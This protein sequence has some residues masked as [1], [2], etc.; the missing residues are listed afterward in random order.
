MSE[1]N[2]AAVDDSEAAVAA[3]RGPSYTSAED[4]CLV[5]AFMRTSED[6]IVGANQRSNQFK[7]KFF[8]EYKRLIKDVNGR[9]GT[10]FPDRTQA[11]AFNRFKKMSRLALKLI[12][13]KASVGDPPSGDTEREEWDKAVKKAF[14]TRNANAKN[15]IENVYTCKNFLE[16]FP[17]WR[18]YEEDDQAAANKKR[19]R[20]EGNKKAKE[21]KADQ[22]FVLNCLSSTS[23]ANNEEA[24]KKQRLMEKKEEALSVIGESMSMV[25]KAMVN[26]QELQLLPYLSP[27]SKKKLANAMFNKKMA[28]LEAEHQGNGNAD[29]GRN[30]S[31]RVSDMTATRDNVSSPLTTN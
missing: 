6:S 31:N 5:K 18:T 2:L 12:G 4:L 19:S 14:V 13:C 17:K 15:I 11:S 23:S 7:A 22:Q 20:P 16:E 26:N 3:A 30:L 8:E 1:E 24:Q 29:R 28:E 25:A 10:S 27:D 9:L 21:K